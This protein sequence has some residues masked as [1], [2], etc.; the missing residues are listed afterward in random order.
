MR[1]Q[2]L[3]LCAAS[4]QRSGNGEHHHVIAHEFKQRERTCNFIPNHI[5]TQPYPP[6]RSCILVHKKSLCCPYLSCSKYHINFY[7]N[8][9][10]EKHR[11]NQLHVNHDEKVLE[12]SSRTDDGEQ[13]MNG[14]KRVEKLTKMCEERSDDKN[15]N[16]NISGCIESGSLYAS[17]G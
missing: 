11:Y 14:G 1:Q 16:K 17:G 4:M 13:E 15:V 5:Y 6:P 3:S 9:S 8:K 2:E 7:K 10:S 12:K